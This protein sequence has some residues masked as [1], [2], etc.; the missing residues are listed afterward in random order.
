MNFSIQPTIVHRQ[1]ELPMSC[2]AASIAMLFGV[3][4]KLIRKE[5]G[6]NSTGTPWHG[7]LSFFKRIN[8]NV[9]MV[10]I[11]QSYF[12]AIDNLITLSYKFPIYSGA[13]Y[14]AKNQKRGRPCK[15]VHAAL[16]ADGMIYD[17]AE[18]RE[19]G[20]EAYIKTFNK[21]LI[22]DSIIIIDQERPNFL[23]NCRERY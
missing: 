16:I 17:P 5:V 21:E 15:R 11:N 19:I 7:V 10:D 12:D 6:T 3:E 14:L 9:E 2:G 20:G 4:E 13:T 18:D 23:R 1:Q 22:F 8:L